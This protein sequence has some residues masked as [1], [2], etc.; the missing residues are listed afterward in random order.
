[1]NGIFSGIGRGEQ[2][3]TAR[4]R[5]LQR[6]QQRVEGRGFD[7]MCTSSTT[8]IRCLPGDACVADRLD[9]LAHVVDAGAARGVDL[10]HVGGVCPTTISSHERAGTARRVRRP[11]LAVQAARQDAR[12]R[13]LA[14]AARTGQ[15][16]RVRA[17]GRCGS[18]CAA[19]WSRGLCPRDLVEPSTVATCARSPGSSTGETSLRFA[20]P[21][22]ARQDRRAPPPAIRNLCYGCFLPDLTEFTRHVFGRDPAIA[23]R[24]RARADCTGGLGEG[25][26]GARVAR[27]PSIRR[28]PRV[29]PD[30]L[31]PP[32]R[33]SSRFQIVPS[34]SRAP[35]GNALPMLDSRT[36]RSEISITSRSSSCSPST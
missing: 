3:E 8:K 21:A 27:F 26:T 12:Q 4:R 7:S 31:Q 2:E 34:P 18:R 23:A 17:R 16:D 29:L 22:A 32:G 33:H 36:S 19:A 15:Q 5:L 30:P 14:D 6:L 1:M 35:N 28:Y 25:Q 13:R 24:D 20:A 9:Q 11:L 10:L